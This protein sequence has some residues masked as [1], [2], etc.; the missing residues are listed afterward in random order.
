MKHATMESVGIR[1]RPQSLWAS[2]MEGDWQRAGDAYFQAFAQTEDGK[3]PNC[4]TPLGGLLGSFAWSIAH[5]EG[6]CSSCGW[7]CRAIHYVGSSGVPGK[8]GHK[9]EP[10]H[11]FVLSSL[12][13]PYHE[14]FVTRPEAEAS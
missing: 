9:D 7:P 11:L 13:L 4:D 5:G 8:R 3:C 14:D 10:G 1:T 2:I 12:I 6:R